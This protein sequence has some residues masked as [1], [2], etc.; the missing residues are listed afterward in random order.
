MIA[1]LRPRLADHALARRH[2]QAG[3][4]IVVIHDARDGSLCR[5][6]PTAFELVR[7]ADGTRD[8]EG[9][10]LALSRAGIYTRRSE[11]ESVLSELDAL[12]LLDEGVEP[13]PIP[14]EREDRYE[15]PAR[16][17]AAERR[18]ER[19]PGYLFRCTGAGSCCEQYGSVTLTK[20]DTVRAAR[21]GLAHLP[22]DEDGEQV[23]LPAYGGSRTERV[24]MAMVDGRCPQICADGRCGLHVRGGEGAKPVGCRSYPAT[25]IDDGESVRVSVAGEC[26]CVFES[27]GSA[28][29]SVLSAGRVARD[30]EPGL[31]VRRLPV[32]IEVA[33]GHRAPVREVARWSRAVAERITN[34]AVPERLMA[35]AVGLDRGD[36][37]D[38]P[39]A[40]S[41][42]VAGLLASVTALADLMERAARSAESWRSPRDR[43]RRLRRAV[44]DAAR[45]LTDSAASAEA[46]LSVG[47][48]ARDEAFLVRATIFG[49]HIAGE[50][51]L[52]SG[53]RALAA[54]I[55]VGR[56]LAERAPDLGHPLSAVMAAVRGAT[57]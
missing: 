50:I 43:T 52:A 30:L 4:D 5:M 19:L 28:E 55:L 3:E 47:D 10:A 41:A 29:G 24:A 57:G 23:W 39:D 17:A 2:V 44:A 14:T 15:T 35:A 16:G 7:Q 37:V 49:H 36:L 38:W 42:D 48:R 46:L 33:P 8:I 27:L 12:G 34:V 51:D 53:L 22:N 26:Q 45:A 18:L 25:L 6:P 1:K 21:A 31:T 54:R 13:G 9:I 40:T 56:A 20:E 11:I 32:E